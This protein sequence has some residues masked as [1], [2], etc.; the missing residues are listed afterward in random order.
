MIHPT[1]RRRFLTG[2]VALVLGFPAMASASSSILFAIGSD[3][4][5]VIKAADRT[6][7][8][9]GESS[10]I[11]AFRKALKGNRNQELFL[12]HIAIPYFLREVS[13]RHICGIDTVDLPRPAAIYRMMGSPVRTFVVV[14]AAR[15]G[16]IEAV[17]TNGSR[18]TLD[19]GA[20]VKELQQL[21]LHWGKGS[22]FV[23]YNDLQLSKKVAPQR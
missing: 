6:R 19:L 4:A 1:D 23:S 18:W 11:L 21:P 14:D 13:F 10:D 9:M 16:R 20:Q 3:T 15:P 12:L 22:R 7:Q 5:H 2:L 8:P 17:A